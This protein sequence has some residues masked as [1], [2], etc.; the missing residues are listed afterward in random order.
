MPAA[1]LHT[2]ACLH[3]IIPRQLTLEVPALFSFGPVTRWAAKEVCQD[4]S[5]SEALFALFL[6]SLPGFL[7]IMQPAR[8]AGLLLFVRLS[9]HAATATSD[10]GPRWIMGVTYGPARCIVTASS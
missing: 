6:E 8:A 9:L 5:P 3:K 4:L 7:I 1:S 10:T 2:A